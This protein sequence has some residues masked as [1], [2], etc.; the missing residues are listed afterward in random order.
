M[1]NTYIINP[2]KTRKIYDLKQATEILKQYG[3]SHNVNKT[4]NLIL[5]GRLVALNS[6]SP[7]RWRTGLEVTEKAIYD[8]VIKEIPIMKEILKELNKTEIKTE[9]K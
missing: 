8:Y 2:S 4:N 9:N 5:K 1:E 3:L 6:D 7:D